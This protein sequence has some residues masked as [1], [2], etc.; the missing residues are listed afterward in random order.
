M[1]Q[2]KDKENVS[3]FRLDVSRHKP[4]LLNEVIKIFNPQPNQN[5]I[6]CTLGDGGHTLAILEKIK[7]DGKILAID[8][9]T[10][11]LE[12]FKNNLDKEKLN[13]IIL[14]NDNFKNLEEIVEKNNFQN[15][16]GILLDLGFSSFHIEESK[17][18]FSFM[19]DE[20]LDMRY[21]GE[22][23]NLAAADVINTYTEK[24][25][26][27]I[28]WKYGEERY[29]RRIA[30]KIIEIRRRQKIRTT[31][32]L[33][34]VILSAIPFQVRR[35]KIHPATRV[36]QALRIEVN[37]ELDNLKQVLPKALKMLDLNG[38]LIVI[39]FHSLEDRIVKHGFKEWE[40]TGLVRILTPKPARPSYEEIRENPRSR[41]AKLRASQKV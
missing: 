23:K 32:G 25:L 14:I 39:S 11:T 3:G 38:K 29:S 41:S 2:K 21:G 36:F 20:F 24:E 19:E 22:I 4:V 26:A 16:S 13:R 31:K 33:S 10:I 7:P 37:H 40:K 28:F 8:L 17:K 15:I 30:K 18:G 1:K 35:Q 5:Y 6:D 34:N 27:D 9:E 12:R